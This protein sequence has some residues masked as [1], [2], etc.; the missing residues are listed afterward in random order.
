MPANDNR[1]DVLLIAKC[2]LHDSPTSIKRLWWLTNEQ[3]EAKS[4]KYKVRWLEERGRAAEDDSEAARVERGRVA[5]LMAEL[6][7]LT[8]G[9]KQKKTERV[10]LAAHN[11]ELEIAAAIRN[12]EIRAVMRTVLALKGCVAGGE[13]R[14]STEKSSSQETL[15]KI[16]KLLALFQGRDWTVGGESAH[17]AGCIDAELV[18]IWSVISAPV[19]ESEGTVSG[20]IC[21]LHDDVPVEASSDARVGLRVVCLIMLRCCSLYHFLFLLSLSNDC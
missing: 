13:D 10:T 3:S 14:A 4:T 6:S 2:S 15:E 12:E 1:W 18:R 17:V 20:A 11:F 7:A 19:S 9:T 5:K 8:A 21:S 16:L